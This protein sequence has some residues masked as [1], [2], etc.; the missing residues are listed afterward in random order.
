MKIVII[1][2][3]IFPNNAPR[4]LRATELAKY[5]G[6]KGH[7]VT[8]Y[9]VLGN[10]DYTNFQKE[11]NVKVKAF[12]KTKFAT[13]NSSGEASPG[14]F[15]KIMGRLFGKLLEFPDIELSFKIKSILDAE[16]DIDLLIT[17]AIPYPIHWGTAWYKYKNPKHFATTWVSDCGDPYYGNPITKKYSYF[18]YIENFWVKQTDYISIPLEEAKKAYLPSAQEKIRIIPQAF[19]FDETPID[20]YVKNNIPNFA[21]AGN[22]YSIHRDPTE[23]LEHLCKIDKDFRFHIYTQSMS[24]FEPFK[25]ILGEKLVL[26]SFIPRPELLKRLSRMDFLINIKNLHAVQSPSKLIDYSI[27]KRPILSV[28]KGIEDLNKLDQFLIGNYEGAE[29]IDVNKYDINIVAEQFLKL[30]KNK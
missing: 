17:I 3:C 23:L 22:C 14:L 12:K 2:R 11:H 5:Y 19:N 25:D 7:D 16:K 8:L 21:F 29:V 6:H 27:T 26:N 24:F 9:G 28:G 15:T 20:T 4:A 13:L 10:F 30:A 1:S 18:R